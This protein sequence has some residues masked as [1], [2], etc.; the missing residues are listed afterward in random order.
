MLDKM[1]NIFL[2]GKNLYF[3]YDEKKSPMINGINITLEKGSV[4]GILGLSGSGKTT[5]IKI[6]NGLIPK[7]IQG[8]F[9]GKVMLKGK[10]FKTMTLQEISQN[11]GTVYQDP[12]TQIIFSCVE[13]EMAFGPENLCISREDI[14]KRIDHILELLDI[15]GLR[16][17]NP[18]KLSGG[19]KQLVVLASIL[20]LDVDIII[21]DEAM[22]Q[23]DRQGKKRILKAIQRM[24]SAGKSI[25][26]VEHTI[27]NLSIS[28]EIL[29][30]KEGKLQK[31]E[32]YL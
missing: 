15:Q 21:L 27:E 9:K 31:F 2:E 5:L 23:V 13:D 7:R 26:M 6:L 25:I 14:L 22:S 29:L 4:I 30:L 16:Y 11:I 18:N 17:R 10:N 12:D 8:S 20:T 3:S 28:D 32:G 24:K 1:K 19:E